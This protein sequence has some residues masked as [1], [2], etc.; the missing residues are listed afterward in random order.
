MT[1]RIIICLCLIL[2]TV[3]LGRRSRIVGGT[4][5]DIREFPYIASLRKVST[6]E[7]FC[8]ATIITNW[9]L[10]TAAHCFLSETDK[11]DMFRV[12]T[13]T[14]NSSDISGPS[15][16]IAYVDLH[17]KY[18]GKITPTGSH[19]HDI[20]I[21]TVW[22]PIEFNEF[23][24]KAKL[25]TR[26]SLAN[27]KGYI[28]GWGSKDYPSDETSEQLQKAKMSIVDQDKC[29]KMVDFIIKPEQLCA[30]Q[31]IGI[32]SCIGDSGGPLIIN[33]E[34]VGIS[35]FN[36][37]CARGLPD[38]YTDVYNYLDFILPHIKM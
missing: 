4:D 15:Y 18:N 32:G 17:P 22:R 29:S 28:S 3:T 37:P 25:P 20:A 6:N 24:N 38:I 16:K 27:E 2:S 12:Y 21:I 8:G 7:H 34:V 5:A 9:H 35:S 31:S 13:G 26:N 33:R 19:A 1:I 14:S 23:Q 30:F 11:L 10:L 36:L